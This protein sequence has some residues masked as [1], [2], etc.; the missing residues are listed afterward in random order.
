MEQ[1]EEVSPVA[2]RVKEEKTESDEQRPTL[3]K[4]LKEEPKSNREEPTTSKEEQSPKDALAGKF[5]IF[6]R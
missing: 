1:G 3:S 2:V 6:F 5:K 4:P